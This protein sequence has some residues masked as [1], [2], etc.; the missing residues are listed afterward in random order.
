MTLYST[1]KKV[2][3]KRQKEKKPLKISSNVY[4]R[5][6]IKTNLLERIENKLYAREVLKL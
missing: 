4:F 5:T 6:Q 3:F 2:L 1:N